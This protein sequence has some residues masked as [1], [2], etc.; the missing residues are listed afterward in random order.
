MMLRTVL[1]FIAAAT[2]ALPS[3]GQA[4]A[5]TTPQIDIDLILLEALSSS[6]VYD[7]SPNIGQHR[8]LH[9]F[10]D[11]A[12]NF[13]H[14]IHRSKTEKGLVFK[15]IGTELYVVQFFVIND[16][17]QRLTVFVFLTCFAFMVISNTDSINS[18][19]KRTN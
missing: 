1:P 17:S 18:S 19:I 10:F 6:D 3:L 8:W 11:F 7:L 12:H 9:M 5:I 13:A 2:L 4:G 14:Y 16:R 15:L